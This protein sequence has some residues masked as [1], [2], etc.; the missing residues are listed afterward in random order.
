MF[1]CEPESLEV[2]KLSLEEVWKLNSKT[3]KSGSGTRK[4]GSLEVEPESL[5][6]WKSSQEEIDANPPLAALAPP[7]VRSYSILIKN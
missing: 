1:L 3:W 7:V 2:W 5:E 4:P 6:V